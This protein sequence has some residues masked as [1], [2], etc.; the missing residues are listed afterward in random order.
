MVKTMV[1][2]K[3]LMPLSYE[4]FRDNGEQVMIGAPGFYGYFLETTGPQFS[5]EDG[6]LIFIPNVTPQAACDSLATRKEETKGA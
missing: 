1:K 5:S 4:E 2:T 6:T 3:I